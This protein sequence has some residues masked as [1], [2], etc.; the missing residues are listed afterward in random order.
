MPPYW[1][2]MRNGWIGD[3]SHPV[4]H[5][6]STTIATP[7]NPGRQVSAT[8]LSLAQEKGYELC[9]V[10]RNLLLIQATASVTWITRRFFVLVCVL[11][12]TKLAGW[13]GCKWF[14]ATHEGL[15]G[16]EQDGSKLYTIWDDL[17]SSSVCGPPSTEWLCKFR[18]VTTQLL[19]PM[20][21]WGDHL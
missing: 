18:T 15:F 10:E 17:M 19:I 5:G 4:F 8:K 6:L 14:G 1:E 7:S 20:P 2:M 3:F 12:R 21:K 13:N 11:N 16:V 9:E